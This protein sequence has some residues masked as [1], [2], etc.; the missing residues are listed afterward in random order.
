M[1]KLTRPLCPVAKFCYHFR[2]EGKI[3]KRQIP[4]HDCCHRAD[5]GS[6]PSLH[7]GISTSKMAE[8]ANALEK[9]CGTT[10]TRRFLYIHYQPNI[11][12]CVLAMQR[13][14]SAFR[15][16]KWWRRKRFRRIGFVSDF[17]KNMER[18]G[19][20][21]CAVSFGSATRSLLQPG[22][23]GQACL[24]ES[25]ARQMVLD[26]WHTATTIH[27]FWSTAWA[28]QTGN[29]FHSAYDTL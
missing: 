28:P 16:Q 6:V 20:H 25:L 7:Y 29:S 11:P 1:P 18:T 15:L 3:R 23:K 4:R 22:S 10:G 24:Q 19:T 5:P 8:T 12:A 13:E 26:Q 9:S 27:S 2:L 14:D 17:V 21:P